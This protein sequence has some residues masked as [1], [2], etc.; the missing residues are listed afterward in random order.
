MRSFGRDPHLITTILGDQAHTFFRLSLGVCPSGIKVA[1]TAIDGVV[2]D[3]QGLVFATALF[4][5]DT[6]R[7]ET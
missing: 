3:G 2:Q 4:V 1:D 6:L 5:D 7:A